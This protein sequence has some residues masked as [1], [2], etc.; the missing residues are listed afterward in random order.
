V[1]H[2]VERELTLQIRLLTFTCAPLNIYANILIDVLSLFHPRT[3]YN[4]NKEAP[5]H[6]Q[7]VIELFVICYMLVLLWPIFPQLECAIL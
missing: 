6:L 1:A 7:K 4:S 5:F 3:G 2:K